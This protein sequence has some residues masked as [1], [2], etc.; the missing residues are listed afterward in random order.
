MSDI[1]VIG[2]GLA[3]S[4]AAW[5]AANRGYRVK[6]Y[7]MR[8]KK[9]TPVHHTP[10]CAELVCSNSLRAA[11]LENAVGLLKEEMRQLDSLIMA[12]ADKHRVPAGGALAVD[13][14]LFSLEITR[15]LEE[16][17]NVELVREEL[18]QIPTETVCIV[19]TGPLTEGGMARAIGEL[20]GEQYLYFFDAAAPIVTRDSIDFSK[21]FWA[22]RYDKGDADYLNCPMT[23]EEYEEFYQALVEAQLHEVK[24]FERKMV[25]EG[26]MP[27][28]VMAARG[29]KTLTFGP[30]KPVG[31]V[32]PRTGKRPWAVVQLRM[33]NSAG[34]LFN[35]VGF[36]TNLKWGEQQRVFRMIPGLEQAEFVRF[37]VMHRNSFL[38]GPKVLK[39]TYQ[40]K[41]KDYANIFFA[42]QIT[43]V[44]GYMESAASGLVA[45][46]NAARQITGEPALIFPPDT[47]LGALCNHVGC[48]ISENFQPMNV[49]WGLFPPLEE[50]I[51]AKRERGAEMSRRALASLQE[52]IAGHNIKVEQS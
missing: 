43:G 33:E 35:L 6:L 18:E 40:L 44:E 26:C 23:R 27:V 28:E 24:D 1:T 42:G 37:G 10:L 25:F 8:P 45:G 34:T 17:P 9:N 15:A 3:G 21:A 4:E 47:A 22:S 13:R 14:E 50:R 48:S 11:G 39:P 32:D 20:S 2:A 5:Q 16:H 19:A 49:N 7:E 30:L 12:A 31:L 36:Q 51:K 38:N 29:P 41:N 52:F 46:I